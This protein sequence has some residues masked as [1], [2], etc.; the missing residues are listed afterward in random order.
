MVRENINRDRD[1][2]RD[3]NRNRN[4]N[5]D[6]HSDTERDRDK[7]RDTH[8]SFQNCRF[9][10]LKRRRFFF[11]PETAAKGSYHL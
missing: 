11:R 7:D 4:R 3:R 10:C 8:R 9:L 2:D 1:R 6:R 5:R